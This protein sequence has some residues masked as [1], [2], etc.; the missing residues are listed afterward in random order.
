LGAR[1]AQDHAGLDEEAVVGRTSTGTVRRRQNGNYEVRWRDGRGQRFSK[2]FTTA[3]AAR[4]F[5]Q[6]VLVD[7]QRGDDIDPRRGRRTF[8]EYA[9]DWIAGATPRLR[10]RT[11]ATYRSILDRHLLPEFGDRPVAA[12]DHPLIRLLRKPLL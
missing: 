11:L 2:T 10:P 1:R 5:L 6:R 7:L 3:S 4:E 8:G 9:E 12:L